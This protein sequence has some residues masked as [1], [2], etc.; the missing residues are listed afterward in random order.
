[1][2][3]VNKCHD[4]TA[5]LHSNKLKV[6][7]KCIFPTPGFKVN[8]KRKVPQGINPEILLLE[9]T[10]VAPAG[11]EPDH[12]VT[13]EVSFEEHTSVHYK[14]VEILPDGSKIKVSHSRH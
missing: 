8:L 14:E 2:P 7:G 1:M 10:V 13:I 6:H 9:K 3:D 12:V 5:T 11:I 4:W